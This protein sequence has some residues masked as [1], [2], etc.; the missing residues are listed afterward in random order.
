MKARARDKL[1]DAGADVSGFLDLA[2]ARRTNQTPRRV[3][4]DF[5]ARMIHSLDTERPDAWA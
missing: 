4:V 5:P 1:F 2:R 3:N